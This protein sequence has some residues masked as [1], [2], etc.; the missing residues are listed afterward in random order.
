MLLNIPIL[1]MEN[2]DIWTSPISCN[3][4]TQ[5]GVIVYLTQLLPAKLY[6]SYFAKLK[7]LQ[8]RTKWMAPFPYSSACTEVKCCVF[9]FSLYKYLYKICIKIM[10]AGMLTCETGFS[11]RPFPVKWILWYSKTNATLWISFRLTS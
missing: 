10:Y 6:A 1:F 9:W 4:R 2:Y 5:K 7:S 3:V 8:T 11:Y